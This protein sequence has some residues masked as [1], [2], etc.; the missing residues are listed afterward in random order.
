MAH[1]MR[2]NATHRKV[3]PLLA[4][5]GALAHGLAGCGSSGPNLQSSTTSGSGGSSSSAGTGGSSSSASTG[6][7]GGTGGGVCDPPLAPVT[8]SGTDDVT[9]A[10]PEQLKC[11]A[12]PC[13]CSSKAR[14]LVDHLLACDPIAGG[15]FWAQGAVY[16][17][18]A[19][20]KDGAC[21]L[22]VGEEQE[23]GVTYRRCKLP[24]PI[25]PWAGIA[26]DGD[27][28]MGTAGFLE[29]IVDA[30]ESVGSCCIQPGCPD[31]CATKLPDVPL[32]PATGGLSCM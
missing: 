23:G 13:L 16:A 25:T 18:V 4:I 17:R 1:A 10:D 19:G 24:L 31:P 22:E 29:G 14:E 12:N 27:N 30:C 15:F 26:G 11:F 5:L 8:P 28:T 9:Y 7:T 3:F 32:C 20:R 2:G 21:V 6:G